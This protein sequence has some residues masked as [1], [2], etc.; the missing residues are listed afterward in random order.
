MKSLA[1]YYGWPSCTNADLLRHDIAR[2]AEFYAQ[3]DRVVFGDGLQ[4]PDH[5]DNINTRNIIHKALSLNP[6]MAFYGYLS[7]GFTKSHSLV[8]LQTQI[9]LWKSMLCAGIFVDEAGFD[10]WDI[11]DS[12]TMRSRQIAVLQHAHDLGMCVTF[13]VWNPDFWPIKTVGFS[14]FSHKKKFDAARDPLT[15]V[16]INQRLGIIYLSSNIIQLL[17]NEMSFGELVLL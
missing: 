17:L 4:D 8:K 13:N 6:N 14:S 12:A 7:I 2:I 9:T 3:F 1:I 16:I 5:K 15:L 11:K 10:Y